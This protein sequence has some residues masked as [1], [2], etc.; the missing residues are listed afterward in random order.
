MP[1]SNPFTPLVLCVSIPQTEDFSQLWIVY[2]EITSQ[3]DDTMQN[4]KFKFMI[5][6]KQQESQVFFF[7][8]FTPLAYSI[9]RS[10]KLLSLI[11]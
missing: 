4:I 8:H 7:F 1:G 9:S 11:F 6:R 3:V 10:S 2:G 5:G